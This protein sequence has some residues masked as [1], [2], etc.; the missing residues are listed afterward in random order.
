MREFI[1]LVL[2]LAVGCGSTRAPVNHETRA[3]LPAGQFVTLPR[4]ASS[5]DAVLDS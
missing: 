2:F 4:L 5:L 1:A 3:A